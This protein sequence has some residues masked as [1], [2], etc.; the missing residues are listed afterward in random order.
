MQRRMMTT[1]ALR[2]ARTTAAHRQR[3]GGV[4]VTARRQHEGDTTAVSRRWQAG[5]R[6]CL[7]VG[8]GSG[9]VAR[10]STVDL[11]EMNLIFY[12]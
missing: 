8:S 4:K 12:F 10:L 2:Y 3:G 1:A 7:V 6:G 9:G 11:N 5:G